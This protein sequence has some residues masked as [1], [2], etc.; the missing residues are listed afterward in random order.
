MNYAELIA[1]REA[2]DCIDPI[3][4]EEFECVK[5][6]LKSLEYEYFLAKSRF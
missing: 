1:G 6:N 2:E 4:N 5:M 3:A